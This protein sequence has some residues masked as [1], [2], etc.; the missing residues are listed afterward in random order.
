MK[1]ETASDAELVARSLAGDQEAFRLLV[2][3]FER[4]VLSV[5]SRLIRDPASAEDVTQEAFVKVYRHLHRYDPRW[6]LAS[7]LFKIA[8]N[9][10]IDHL[11]RRHP[12]TVPL[13]LPDAEGEGSW[14]R[15]HA[16]EEEGPEEQAASAELG[17]AVEQALGD[18]RGQ[19][20][21]ILELRFKQGLSYEEI[22]E[23]LG[24]ALGTVKV[25][26][27]RARKQ[28]ADRLRARGFHPP[29]G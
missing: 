21:E 19:Y 12:E 13:E 26:I 23:V 7:W 20:R 2:V 8:H 25:Q 4:P 28:L 5:V 1:P 6:R 17:A 27:H 14:E 18:L 3:R 11:R 15:F 16:P 10:A 24:L 22:A 9:T 29:E